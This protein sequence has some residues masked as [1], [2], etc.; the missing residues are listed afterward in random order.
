MKLVTTLFILFAF[1]TIAFCDEEAEPF[2]FYSDQ[3]VYLLGDSVNVRKEASMDSKSVTKLPIGTRLRIIKKSDVQMNLNGFT[4][5]W[6][7]VEI[8]PRQQGYIWGGKFAWNSSRSSK[9]TDYI[10]HFGLE[11][12]VDG[13]TTYQIR[14][15]K[16]HKEI[17]HLSFEGFGGL[18]KEH[19]FTNHS[20]RGL[21][22]V[23]DVLCV[24]ANGEFCGDEGGTIVFF[25]SG[26][27]LQEIKRLSD[28]TD[29][30]VFATE[31]FIFPSDMEGKKDVILYHEEVGEYIF[32]E[33][34]N[35][36]ESQTINYEK[37]EITTFRWDGKQLVKK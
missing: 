32:S 21:T 8:K 22:N 29:A 26:N 24:D 13:I 34:E 37:N 5:S 30:P 16:N 6:Y 4:M 23:D 31:T 18:M 33:D 10:F 9:N 20:N 1:N 14:V 19:R 25:W 28:F 2:E 3:I 11:K 15:E 27:V 7:L 17:Q 12:V 36:S 35:S